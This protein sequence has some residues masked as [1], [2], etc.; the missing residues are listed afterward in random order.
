MISGLWIFGTGQAFIINAEIGVSP[1]TVLAQGIGFQLD[2]SIGFATFVIS[3][4]VLILWI[5]LKEKPGLGTLMNTVLI[6]V[7]ID[8]MMPLLPQPSYWYL[9]LIQTLFGVLVVGVGSCFYLTANLGPGPRDGWMTSIQR[10]TG[11]P[12]S[13]VRTGIEFTALI[14]GWF[15]G[16]S[17]GLGTLLFAVGIGPALSFSL[18]LIGSWHVTNRY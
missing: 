2:W 12:I 16:G 6:A 1:W 18:T 15:L 7:S 3:L 10:R 11:W 13:R 14:A 8:I 5:P 17:V 9:A 4:V